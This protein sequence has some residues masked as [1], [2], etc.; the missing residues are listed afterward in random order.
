[1]LGAP[2]RGNAFAGDLAVLQ[3]VQPTNDT[4]TGGNSAIS[5]YALGRTYARSERRLHADLMPLTRATQERAAPVKAMFAEI[6]HLP[7][8]AT[9]QQY[10]NCVTRTLL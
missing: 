9:C 4:L 10:R 7:P 6:C 2:V 1:M 8:H 3:P 5:R